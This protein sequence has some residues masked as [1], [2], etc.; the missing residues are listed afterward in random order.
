MIEEDFIRIFFDD[1]PTT[2]Y[3]KGSLILMSDEEPEGMYYLKSGFVRQYAKK[4]DGSVLYLHIYRPGSC[5]PLMWLFNDTKNRY[6][7]EAMTE[8]VIRKAPGAKV[9]A[10][11]GKHPEIVEYFMGRIL[12]G[13][14]GIL[15]RM[16]SLVLDNAYR[17]TILLF[18]YFAKTFGVKEGNRIRITVP[19]SH[20]EIAL[21]IGTARETASVVTEQLKQKGI[22][23]YHGKHYEICDVN[24]LEGEVAKTQ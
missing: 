17:K 10:F 1:F 2:T 22:I 14:D 16:E 9:K 13:L 21:W 4:A 5:F 20:R 15:A 23:N 3:K 18:G 11:F 8:A 24:A 12:L 7:Y 6:T 19:M